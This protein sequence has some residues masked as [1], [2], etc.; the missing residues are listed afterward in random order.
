MVW[1]E[2]GNF[3]TKTKQKPVEFKNKILALKNSDEPGFHKQPCETWHIV[4]DG[5]VEFISQ[6]PPVR[7]LTEKIEE[8]LKSKR[9]YNKY[10]ERD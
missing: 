3:K 2:T 7:K 9:A 6:I 5:N 1:Y 10:L 8:Y 4:I